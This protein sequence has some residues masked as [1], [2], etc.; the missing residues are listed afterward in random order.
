MIA[1]PVQLVLSR[2]RERGHEPHPAGKGWS[3]TCPT[4]EDKSPSLSVG[5]GDTGGAVLHC[6]AGCEPGAVVAALGLTTRDLFA[7]DLKAPA[8]RRKV[9]KPPRTFLTWEAA[10]NSVADG[11]GTP[12]MAWEY[13]DAQ[14]ALVGVVCRWNLPEGKKCIPPVSPQP[15]GSWAA[16]GMAKLRPLYRLPD[17]IAAETVYVCEGEKAA[18]AIRSLGLIATTSSFGAKAPHLTDWSQLVG[19]NVVILPDHDEEGEKYAVAVLKLAT[20]AGVASA[21]IVHL[22]DIWQGIEKADD[23]YDWV[24]AHV[25]IDRDDL[26]AMLEQ[27]AAAARKDEPTEGPVMVCVAD[28][29]PR[30]VSWL[31]PKRVPLG[32]LTL[33][34]GRPKEGK[35]FPTTDM[36]SRV[37]TGT[38]WPDGSEC[39]KGSVILISAEDD[40]HDTIRPRLDAHYADTS[41]VHLLKAVRYLDEKGK[42]HEVMFMLVDV[43]ALETALASKPDWKLVVIDPIGSFLGRRTN[44]HRDN[45]VRA[46]L[47]PVA[48][49]A[50]KYGIAV[51]VVCH[52]RKTPGTNA[53]EQTLGS[54]GF[55]GIARAVWHM[56][57]DSEDKSRRLLLPGG[58][59]LAGDVTGL[60]FTI[61][62]E[63][64]TLSWEREPVAMSADDA[65]AAA[66]EKPRREKPGPAPE[67][68]D[69]AVE[70]LSE[71]LAAGPRLTNDIIEQWTNGEGGSKKT[72]T[73]AKKALGVEAY[74]PENP[75]PWWWRR[76]APW[77][78]GQ[79]QE[80]ASRKEDAPDP[81]DL[82]GK[83]PGTI[84]FPE[85]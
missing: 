32:R 67:K 55:V 20:E 39:P 38:D 45:E 75:G 22:A 5:V 61:N 13:H 8:M 44:A 47:A 16:T 7:D 11:R 35:S 24:E 72:L 58:Q 25:A 76:P 80:P 2:L 82:L 19:K 73:R 50:E 4:H 29:E 1:D 62:G 83:T 69:E 65:L 68:R 12:S 84:A 43:V 57:R 6:H 81:L 71:I 23:A 74:R 3:S 46:V 64:A 60:A 56:T 14:G 48:R 9:E 17:V 21:V 31:W 59:N 10:A 49:L 33:L 15:D 26:V 79:E 70:W 66:C 18:D 54:R 36:A 77:D 85:A 30:E 28:V 78:V 42:P 37:T 34:V 63:P 41:R 40:P 52:T 51:L 53:D 27:L